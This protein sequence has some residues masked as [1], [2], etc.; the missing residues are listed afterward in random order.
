MSQNVLDYPIQ[1]RAMCLRLL[2]N[3]EALVSQLDER[4]ET[5]VSCG[6]GLFV[7]PCHLVRLFCGGHARSAFAVER[8]AGRRIVE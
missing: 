4:L 3:V 1:K 8:A 6:G 7:G 2:L 5:E